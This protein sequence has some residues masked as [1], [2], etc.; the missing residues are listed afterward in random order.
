MIVVVGSDGIVTSQRSVD[1][2]LSRDPALH[3]ELVELQ[4]D[5]DEPAAAVD[6]KGKVPALKDEK[7]SGQLIAKEAAAKGRIGWGPCKPVS[8]ST[9]RYL[10]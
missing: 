2:A 10:R 3:A 5:K 8:S 4:E 9:L 1:D 7:P 6:I